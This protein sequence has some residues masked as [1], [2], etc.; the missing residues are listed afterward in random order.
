MALPL[1]VAALLLLGSSL[2]HCGDSGAAEPEPLGPLGLGEVCAGGLQC[3]TGLTCSRGLFLDQCSNQCSTTP[4]CTQANPGS[5]CF[6]GQ[7]REC[8]LP[9]TTSAECPVS[10]MC[11]ANLSACRVGGPEPTTP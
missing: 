6:G 11:D 3:E 8:G 5:D 4:G 7:A 2:G 10:T 1:R 9:C